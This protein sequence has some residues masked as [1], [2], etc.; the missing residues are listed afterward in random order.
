VSKVSASF[1]SG[2]RNIPIKIH[3]GPWWVN[4]SARH[5][6]GVKER[7]WYVVARSIRRQIPLWPGLHNAA[8]TGGH[9]RNMSI[10]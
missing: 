3:V 6:V 1:I 5:S 8:L 4:L 9:P 7:L 10:T 2:Q